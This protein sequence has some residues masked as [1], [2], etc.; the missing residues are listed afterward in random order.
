MTR[1]ASL[2]TRWQTHIAPQI[3]RI[4]LWLVTLVS[5]C[6]LTA[7]PWFPW[8]YHLVGLVEE[9][10]WFQD[11]EIGRNSSVLFGQSNRVLVLWPTYLGYVLSQNS[12]AGLF[13]M[14]GALVVAKS[15]A[16]YGI[17]REVA[18]AYRWLAYAAAVLLA[19]NATNLMA[20]Y[21]RVL[22]YHALVVTL[23][24]AIYCLLLYWRTQTRL[25][26]IPMFIALLFSTATVETAFPLIAFAPLLLVYLNGGRLSKRVFGVTAL[27]YAVPFVVGVWMILLFLGGAMR[28]GQNITSSLPL[29]TTLQLL[30]RAIAHSLLLSWYT[31]QLLP[32][33]A[34]GA[35][36]GLVALVGGLWVPFTKMGGLS[37]QRRL[38]G[39]LLISLVVIVLGLVMYLRSIHIVEYDYSFMMSMLGVSMFWATWLTLFA[40]PWVRLAGLVVLVW[41]GISG[42][43][44]QTQQMRA[45][46]AASARFVSE[47]IR[48]VPNPTTDVAIIIFDQRP[49]QQLTFPL[50][51]NLGLFAS[52]SNAFT[53]QEVFRWAYQRQE[54]VIGRCSNTPLYVPCAFAADGVVVSD[55]P[56]VVDFQVVYPYAQVI[57]FNVYGDGRTELLQ[58]LP[59]EY[60]Q[61]ID[62]S[63]YNPTPLIEQAQ[64]PLPARWQTFYQASQT[65]G[66][67]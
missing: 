4:P 57:A 37:H 15:M 6:V 8:N 52:Y 11:F 16:L 12:F 50:E 18:P 9:H 39:F 13:V 41:L 30:L 14:L 35:V 25:W 38:L 34:L 49:T 63:A 61:G 2:L 42:L 62:T 10:V 22:N 58:V 27:W 51:R 5:V 19:V 48:T 64:G 66:L 1:I 45:F 53:S 23:L 21:S 24:V 28:Y 47:V 31:P 7:L 40:R 44:V 32:F 60:T 29:D 54:V 55:N 3:A 43:A 46:S 65:S 26:L 67:P 33:L 20:L 17:M 36:G 56:A 59:M